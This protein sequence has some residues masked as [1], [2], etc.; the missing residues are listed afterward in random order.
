MREG[1][2]GTSG[3]WIVAATVLASGMAF[4]DSTVVNVALP[5]I[6]RDLGGGIAGLQWSI[7]AYLLTLSAL[8]LIGGSLGDLYGRKR[9]FAVG[10]IGFAGCSLLC[11][12]A[13]TMPALIGARAV[14]GAAAALLIPGSLAIIAAEFEGDLR[15]KAIGLWTGLAGIAA[16]I[17]PF[18]GGALVD[19]ASWRLVFIINL[20]LAAVAIWITRSHVPESRDPAIGRRPDVAGALATATALA[21]LTY[22]LIEGPACGFTSADVVLGAVLGGAALIVFIL[23]EQ[24]APD[25]MLPFALFR[26]RQFTGANLVTLLVYAALS[27]AL[28]FVV[29]QLQVEMAYSATAA[30]AALIPVTMIML[31]LSPVAGRVAGRIGPRAPMTLGPLVIAAGFVLFTRIE[32]GSGYVTGVLPATALFGLGLSIT[33]AP[34]TTAVL[35]AIEQ[36][37]AGIGSAV[38]NAVARL[39][40]LL[41]IAL[42]PIAAGVAGAERAALSTDAFRTAMLI[43]AGL[44]AAGAAIAAVTIRGPLV[45]VP[46]TRPDAADGN[47][48]CGPGWCLEHPATMER[49]GA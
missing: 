2:L 29:L 38:N 49:P 1:G 46:V 5:A 4:L 3:R 18:V 24:R 44:A 14:Q 26:S 32:P 8:L 37:H 34:L 42:L 27:G 16:A 10:L 28:F 36:R 30:G 11:G 33:V 48:V 6:G 31:V 21:G 45:P 22:A 35:G 39:A 43:N 20:P 9:V 41:A 47:S 40:G 7:D 23:F 17:G 13:P 25:P 19:A 12:I 15:G